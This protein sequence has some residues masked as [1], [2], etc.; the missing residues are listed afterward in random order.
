LQVVN[1]GVGTSSLYG[2]NI[3]FI[4]TATVS[5]GHVVSVAITNPGTGYT[6]TNLPYVFFDAP[7]SYSNIPLV[8][9]SESKS[10]VGTEA[11]VDVVVGQGSSVISFEIKNYGYG[12][13][14][15]EILTIP[16]TG[17]IGIP[18]NSS[19]PFEE[20]QILIER[21][22]ND[23]FSAWSIG[24][25]QV[26]D[27]IDSLFDGERTEFPIL[28][29]GNQTTI[30]SRTGSNI[31]IEQTLLIFI[32]DVL[33]VPGEG[34]RF[35]G[36]SVI[37]FSEPPVEGDT[38]KL[39]FYRGTGDVDTISVDVLETVKPG[40]TLQ[41]NSDDALYQQ[42]KRSVNEIVSSDIV[43][44]NVYPGPGISNDPN[45]LRPVTWCKQMTD[46]VI[47][48]VSVTKD[49][50]Q[51]EPYIYPVTNI[52]QDVT[53]S[54]AEIFVESVKTFFDSA[55]EYVQDGTTEKPQKNVII[56]SQDEVVGAA[57]SAVVS[58]GGSITSITITDGGVGYTTAPT[59]TISSPV[60]IGTTFATATASIT[61]GVV[62]SISVSYAGYGYTS[63]NPPQ[64]LIESPIIKYEQIRDVD[65]SG[66]F[67]IITGIS[68][69]TSGVAST[70]I[71]FDLF[72]PLDSYLRDLDINQVGIATTGI[73]GIQTGYYFIVD[74][75]NVGNS[76]NSLN[77][78]NSVVGVGSTYLDNIYQA[79]AVSIAQTAVPGI[80]ITYVT[81]V[82]VS[83][84]DY[85]G[86]SGIGY[87]S[88]FGNYSWGRL[89]NL[90][91]ENPNS[92]EIY[93]NGVSGISTSPVVRRLNKLKYSNYN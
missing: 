4:G 1:V 24:D 89:S 48:E 82:T 75:S 77:Q 40:D 47:D 49:R 51:Y 87:S 67:G 10:G 5:N 68:T 18:T 39:I 45:L 30:R 74:N 66:D 13:D 6:S 80:G 14:Q 79:V 36:G 22:F 54:S 53:E 84:E 64:I 78:S 27:P 42:S 20:F 69:V 93:N 34:Y 23:E 37:T 7:L 43:R 52:I 58:V 46:M 56:F 21:T 28:I 73:S 91:R 26:L 9:S 50:V 8:Y 57:A 16:T 81:Q 11:V 55:D 61:A 12:Y 76:V 35:K 83:V 85:N 71:T 92:F 19:L 59:V 17:T 38:S 25:L 41:I 32:N 72:I 31:D 44:T 33:Q 86:L 29:N 90:I 88:Y 62:T 63:T 70:G 65:Y 15:W 3:E 2:P 60:G